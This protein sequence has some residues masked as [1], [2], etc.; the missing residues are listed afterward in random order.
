V[1]PPPKVPRETIKPR[2]GRRAAGGGQSETAVG[3][4]CVTVQPWQIHDGSL[5]EGKLSKEV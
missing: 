3:E 4:G 2:H 1:S 5:Q